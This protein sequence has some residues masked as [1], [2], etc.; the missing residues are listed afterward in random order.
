MP[1]AAPSAV[2]AFRPSSPSPA[3][4]V[5][6]P[7]TPSVLPPP[8]LVHNQHQEVRRLFEKFV[9]P[10][11]GRFDLVLTRGRGTQVWDAAGRR[12]LDFG[13]GIAVTALGHAH[14][15]VAR[16]LAEQA[17]CLLHVS[18]L[19]YSEPQGRLAEA[20]VRLAGPGKVFFANSGAE[21]N[22]GLFKLARRFG[23]QNPGP[24]GPRHE[25]LTARHSFHG[26][27]LAGISATGQEKVKDGFGPMVEGFRCDLPFNDLEAAREAVSPRTAAILIEAVQG[28]GGITPATADYLSGLRRLCDEHNLLLLFD[29]VQCGHFRTGRYH[30]WQRILEQHPAGESFRADGFSTAKSLGGGFPISAFWVAEK[31]ADLLGPGSHASTFGGTPLGCAV[32]L[33]VLEIIERE[34]LAERVRTVG[35]WMRQEIAALATEFP[36]VVRSARG[37]GFMLGIELAPAGE[38]GPFAAG[39]SPALQMVERLHEAGLLTIPSGTQVVRLLPP[40]NLSTAEAEEGLGIIRKVVARLAGSSPSR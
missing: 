26:R 5:R 19:Y 14:P 33:K 23:H 29:E 2:L 39:S 24:E 27:T 32:A 37:L 18:N 13:G 9:I 12:H 20:L 16:T 1:A 3:L 40:L 17:Q 30:G 34:G 38:A 31:W 36:S 15:E 28:E 7:S 11:Y 6:E 4:T 21:A 22:E 10:S 35:D 8:P 25:I